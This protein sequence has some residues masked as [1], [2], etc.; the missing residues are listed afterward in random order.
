MLQINE[1]S[2]NLLLPSLSSTG[3]NFL[4]TNLE[5]DTTYLIR[6]ASRN[7]AGFSDYTRVEKCR[8]L[9][10]EPRAS[11][12]IHTMPALL[13]LISATLLLVGLRLRH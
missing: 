5:P 10:L 9:S 11:A 2:T 3:A 13:E 8:T 6:A 7:L 1:S 12:G 4:I